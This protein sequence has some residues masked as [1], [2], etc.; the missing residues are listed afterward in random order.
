MDLYFCQGNVIGIGLLYKQFLALCIAVFYRNIDN[1]FYA[2]LF[3]LGCVLDNVFAGTFI[4]ERIS[5][6]LVYI[7][8]VVFPYLFQSVRSPNIKLWIVLIILIYFTI[9]SFT[10]LEKH[11]AVPYRTIIN[12]DLKNPPVEYYEE[13]I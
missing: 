10:G 4:F 11:G 6:Y 12:E 13:N 3:L 1:K 7:N 5:N 2:T 9:E 8:I